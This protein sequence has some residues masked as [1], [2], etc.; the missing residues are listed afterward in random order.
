MSA[1]PRYGYVKGERNAVSYPVD[2]GTTAMPG[3]H[4]TSV[5]P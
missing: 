4:R 1:N 2:S 3:R 5:S